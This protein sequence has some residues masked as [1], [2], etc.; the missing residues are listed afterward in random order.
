MAKQDR[1]NEI[2]REIREG[3]RENRRGVDTARRKGGARRTLPLLLAL[4]L[5]LGAVGYAAFRDVN[6]MDSL[7]R[8][9]SYNKTVQNAD[10]KS[11]L[12]RFDSD[13]TAKYEPLGKGLL[14]VSTTR[15]LLLGEHG[16]ELWSQTVNFKNPAIE[17]GGQ[18]AAAYDVGGQELYILG[19]RGLVR[20][21]SDACGNGLLAVSLNAS[22]Y[23]ALTTRK[24]GFRASVAA[25]TPS[26]EIAFEFNSSERYISDARVLSDNRHLAAVTLGEADGMFASTIT[27]Y[28]FDSE[29]PIN[30]TT[31]S[32]SMVFSLGSAGDA[33][34]A[35]QDDRLTLFHTDGSL[36]G[37][38]RYG[39]PYLRGLA[40]GG[41]DFTVLLLSR[42]R[43]G[44][45]LRLVSV[46]AEG[47]SL[48]SMDV[49]QEIL[50]VSA[51]GRYIAVLYS[52]SLSIY[53]S[54]FTL[55]A[56][57]SGTD[58]ARQV[59]MRSDGTALLLGTSRA[60]LYVP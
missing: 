53:T 42:Y 52:D 15:V 18:V 54:D 8:L 58:Y 36:A 6:N 44:S 55:C 11:E 56:S 41:S 60:W 21:M 4:L 13:R 38:Y 37:N 31:L 46:D 20:D 27:F 59:I 28:A 48:G 14:I 35:L 25:Y 39:Y 12:F 16:E 10:G 51:A 19:A 9:L 17:T 33:L 22:D 34:T 29:K 49:R 57:L 50:C 26:G 32:G 7:R 47:A 2:Q 24:S 1:D 5:V 40:S 23:L 43:S 30:S 45:V 3:I